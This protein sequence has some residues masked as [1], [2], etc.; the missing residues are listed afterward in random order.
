MTP[1]TSGRRAN[2]ISFCLST[3]ISAAVPGILAKSTA[4]TVRIGPVYPVTICVAP[5]GAA[6]SACTFS[7][8]PG[9]LMMVRLNGFVRLKAPLR[10]W[11]RM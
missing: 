7:Q 1:P 2:A 8:G 5:P 10:P 3:S 11:I 6:V 4:I 9:V